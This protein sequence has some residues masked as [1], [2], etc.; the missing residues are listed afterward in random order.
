MPI[1]EILSLL[2]LLP[3]LI[4]ALESVIPTLE[5]AVQGQPITEEQIAAV[6]ATRRALEAQAFPAAGT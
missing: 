5:A 6:I 2:A 4:P 3:S 1:T